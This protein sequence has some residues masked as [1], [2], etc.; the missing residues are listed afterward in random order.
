MEYEEKEKKA[1]MFFSNY[2]IFIPE[3]IARNPDGTPK[4]VKEEFKYKQ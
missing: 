4:E 1:K 3:D 2:G